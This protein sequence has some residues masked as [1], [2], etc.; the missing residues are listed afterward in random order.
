M[1]SIRSLKHSIWQQLTVNLTYAV[2]SV[3]VQVLLCLLWEGNV[4]LEE[5]SVSPTCE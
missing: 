1:G 5:T 2:C 4:Q 3:M